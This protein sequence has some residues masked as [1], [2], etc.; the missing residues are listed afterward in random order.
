MLLF[1]ATFCLNKRASE[2]EKIGKL[3]LQVFKMAE[4]LKMAEKLVFR[5]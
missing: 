2:I 3:F 4:I 5:P 1:F